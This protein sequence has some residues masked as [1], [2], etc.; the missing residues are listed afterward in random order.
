M[1]CFIEKLWGAGRQMGDK[2]LVA[3]NISM[4]V[5]I[6]G[7]SCRKIFP[8][9]AISLLHP[10]PRKFGKQCVEKKKNR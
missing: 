10:V 8:P 7:N 2:R 9:D 1:T 6:A 3:I 5:K 4:P